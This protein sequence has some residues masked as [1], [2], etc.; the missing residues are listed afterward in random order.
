MGSA[1]VFVLAAMV[2]GSVQD[3]ARAPG[4]DRLYGRVTTAAGQV[5]EG[6]LRW[7]RNEGSWADMLNGIKEMDP[8]NRREADS[9]GVRDGR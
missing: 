5:L 9:L 2:V 1:G 4:G 3:P 7:D 8:E 6:Y